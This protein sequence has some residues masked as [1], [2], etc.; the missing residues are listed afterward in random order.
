VAALRERPTKTG[1]RMA[2]VTLEDLSGSI[3]AV[4]FPKLYKE[5]G[6]TLAP[7]ACILIK[8]TVSVRN[9]DVSLTIENLKPL[10]ASAPVPAHA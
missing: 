2:W 1:K 4:I 5:H 8:G 10:E 7:G 9:G 3:E 6:K